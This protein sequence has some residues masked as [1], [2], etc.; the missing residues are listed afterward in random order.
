MTYTKYKIAIVMWYDKGIADYAD[1]AADIN[2]QFCKA[3][4]S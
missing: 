3:N 1:I 2:E 4:G